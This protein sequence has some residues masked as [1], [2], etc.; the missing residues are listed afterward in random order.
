M[1]AKQKTQLLLGT[2][3]GLLQFQWAMGKWKFVRQSFPGVPVPYACIDPRTGAIWASL[4]H[5]HWGT[6]LNV[7]TDNGKT[8]KELETPKYPED[9]VLKDNKKAIL[10]YIWYIA[11]G[12]N[13][14]TN[15]VYLGTCPGGL[16]VTDDY[17]K[18]FSLVE[19]LWN[20][21]SRID[22]WFGGGRD[23][24]GIC[25]FAVDPKNSQRVI[26]GVS[27]GGV[28]EST[29]GLKTWE[30][31]TTGL[32]A[33]FL[34]NPYAEFGHDPHYM[35]ASPSNFE[36]LWQQ[37]HC[38]IF[39]S[40]DGGKNWTDISQKK[41][42]AKFGWAICVDEKDANTAWVVPAIADA[43]RMAVA[44][45]LM[46]C[47]TENGGKTW[48]TLTKG[49]PQKGC[50]DITYRH[51]LHIKGEKLAFGTTTGNVYVSSNG[52]DKWSC[53]G[54]NFPPVYSVRFG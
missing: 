9:A 14:E 49:L 22:N 53:L 34:P 45:K 31:R 11:P 33:D 18:S 6:K 19:S 39:R 17:G 51:A 30:T 52:G 4:D 36:V 10:D 50:Y 41:G 2:R 38:G 1:A 24:P 20:H 32:R 54:N 43:M 46:V 42:P 8:W 16:F 29:D 40:V 47:R 23:T 3:K 7:S 12:G 27:C 35:T 13:N 26:A 25:S 15:R 44:G 28:F 5:G 21:P 37:N 48:K